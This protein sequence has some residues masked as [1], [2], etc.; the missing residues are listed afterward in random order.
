MKKN[1][2]YVLRHIKWCLF[3]MLVFS[4]LARAQTN[5]VTV[6]GI[7]NDEKG[8][9]IPGV[10]VVQKSTKKASETDLNGNFKLINVPANATLIFSFVGYVTKEIP[11]NGKTQLNIS[12]LP[13][14][15]SLNDVVVVG[16]GTQRRAATTGAIASVKADEL[17]QTPIANVAQGLQSRV[18]GVQITQNS[19]APGG[20]I[21]VRIRGINSINGTSEPLYVIDGI[22]VV[23]SGGI[24]DISPLSTIN[25]EDIESIDVLKDASSTAIYGS[26]GANGVVLITTKRGKNGTTKVAF[27]SYYGQQK[28]TKTLAVLNAAE[29]AKSDNE[30][31]NRIIYADPLS[32]GEGT[33]WQELIFRT[34]PIQSHQLSINGGSEKTQFLVSGN[35]TAQDGIVVNS[36]FKRYSFRVNLDHQISETFKV[37]TSLS[38]SYSVNN[39][40]PY[41]STSQDGAAFSGS[42]MGAALAAPPTLLPYREDGT[43]YPF[44]LQSGGVNAEVVNPLGLASILNKTDVKRT[45]ANVFGEARLLPG[46]TYRASFSADLQSSLRNFYSPRSIVNPL[47]VNVTSGNA[48]KTN[49]N[50]TL[51]LHESILTYDKKFHEHHSLKVTGVFATQSNHFTS[52]SANSNGFGNDVTANEAL[53]LGLVQSVS[54][55]R[56]AYRI[57]SYLGRINYGF[58]DKYF[59]DLTARKD[60]SSVFGA[61]HKYGFF[62]AVAVAWRVIEEPFMQEQN[63]IDDLKIRASYGKTGNAGAISPYQSLSLVGTSGNNNYEFNR[64]YNLGI[65]ATGISNPDLRW[66]QSL[67]TNIGVD[68]AFLKNRITFIVD[69]YDKKTT[70]LIYNQLLPLS[71][72]YSSMLGNFASIQN[73]GIE[74]AANAKLLTGN[75]KWSV[76][77][78]FSINR[79]EVLSIVGGVSETFISSYSVIKV[80]QPLGIFKTYVF[81]GIYQTGETVLSGSGSRVGGTKVKDVNGDGIISS[82]DQVI[83][84]NPNPKFIYGFSSNMGYKNFDLSAFFAG[85]E[86]NRIY[87]LS[88]Y[89]FENPSGGKNTFAGVASRWST[90]NASNEFVSTQGNQ[91]SRLPISDRFIEDGSFLRLKNVTLGYKLPPIKSIYSLRLYVSA[92]NLFTMTNYTGYDPEVNSFGNSNTVLGVDNIVYP[93]SKSILFGVQLAF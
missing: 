88:R 77:G 41:G 72:G 34:A 9:P 80:G 57:D 5:V 90:T 21:S 56:T 20:N 31:Y 81:D 83:S 19:A 69:V 78:N 8:I 22:Q 25:P 15:K 58:K 51:L 23:N 37:G 52:N 75:F 60:G 45:L 79:N 11:L 1:Y 65:A 50:S 84:G 17:T 26:R 13:D 76:N 29:F 33:D 12:L 36:D 61:S 35:F 24:T 16:Y 64:A 32:V 86:G 10:T 82:S 91:G 66:E 44:A 2:F 48:A 62:P 43:L 42:L 55:N 54:S 3:V 87:N 92:N 71:S 38:P 67:Q 47:T 40:V 28:V 27:D 70:G 73:R 39:S 18:S 68:L 53:Q 4:E 7:V 93:Q 63:F 85:S 6:S 14:S 89:N 46:L 30:V 74:M 59:L 49:A